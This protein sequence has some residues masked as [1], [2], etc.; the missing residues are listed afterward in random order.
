V[1]LRKEKDK[2]YLGI[3][4]VAPN[5]QGTGIG[6]KLLIAGEE[7]AKSLGINTMIMTVISVRKELIDWYVRHGYQ[8]TGERKPFVVPDTR[9]GIPKKQLEFV[10]LEKKLP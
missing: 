7:H 5:T 9:W 4:S 2:L 1:E 3:L 8:L 10:V 6:K